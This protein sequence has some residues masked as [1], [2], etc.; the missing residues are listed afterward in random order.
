S[1]AGALIYGHDN[2][3]D[4]TVK[5]GDVGDDTVFGTSNRDV[6]LCGA[7][8]D[9]VSGRGGGDVLLGGNGNQTLIAGS[10]ASVLIGGTGN[11]NLYASYPGDTFAPAG[12]NTNWLV[13][14]NSLQAQA[15]L[16]TAELDLRTLLDGV[17]QNKADS[18]VQPTDLAQ[19]YAPYA[20]VT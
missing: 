20:T 10:G 11:N 19:L 9:W 4:S 17:L 5:A 2:Y 15:N 1:T 16:D 6:V 14:L 8:N 13:A 7:G 18:S 3:Y 12:Q